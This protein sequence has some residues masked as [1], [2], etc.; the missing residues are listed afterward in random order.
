MTKGS[1]GH[2]LSHE[3]SGSHNGEYEDDSILACSAVQSR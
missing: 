3:I 1:I 2:I